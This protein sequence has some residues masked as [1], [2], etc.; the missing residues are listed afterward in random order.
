MPSNHSHSSFALNPKDALERLKAGNTRFLTG[1]THAPTLE[2]HL[3]D[4]QSKG[5]QP[6]ATILGC[7]DSRVPPELIFDAWLGELFV[8]RVAGNVI[9]PTILGTLQYATRHLHTPLFVVM[10]H[11]GCGAVDAA[12][13]YKFGGHKQAEKVETL[14]ENIIPSL[15]GINPSMEKTELLASAIEANVRHTVKTLSETPE[16]M[17]QIAQGA[18]LI[19][20]IYDIHTGK[21][22]F[23]D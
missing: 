2:R 9:G 4:T 22:R 21:V 5:Q 15:D 7:S 3:L 6:Y 13:S 1:N 20:A 17:S 10:G 14:L 8:I 18:M 11:E 16:G 23:L 12:I 19:G